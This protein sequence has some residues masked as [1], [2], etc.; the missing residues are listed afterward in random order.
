MNKLSRLGLLALA[1]TVSTVANAKGERYGGSINMLSIDSIEYKE[2]TSGT[3]DALRYGFVHTRPIDEDN[4]RWRWW[5]G[6]NYINESID[7]PANGIYQEVTNYELRIVPQYALGSWSIF[8]PYIGAGLSAGYSQYSNR[9]VVDSDG[10]KYGSQLEDIDQFEAGA[11]ATIGTVIK[12]G[13]NPDAHL[14]II[15]QASYILPVYNDGLG[16]VEFTVSLLF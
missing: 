16:G 7:A 14:Q 12:L 6:F 3:V 13:S 8:T 11:V 2:G 5:L 1:C 15:P 4:N 10:F 9:W